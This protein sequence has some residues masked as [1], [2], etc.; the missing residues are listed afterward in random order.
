MPPVR[1]LQLRDVTSDFGAAPE[2]AGQSS[3]RCGT[4]IR[5]FE[6][7]LGF[8]RLGI[9]IRPLATTLSRATT[10]HA[11]TAPNMPAD[12]QAIYGE[13]RI[14]LAGFARDLYAKVRKIATALPIIR[15]IVNPWK[16]GA[17]HRLSPT[18]LQ[19]DYSV[20]PY[21]FLEAR[22]FTDIAILPKSHGLP[23]TDLTVKDAKW[24]VACY[25]LRQQGQQHPYVR[26]N[27]LQ[28]SSLRACLPTGPRSRCVSRGRKRASKK[29]SKPTRIS[30]RLKKGRVQ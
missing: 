1:R 9:Y 10:H 20:V 14:V 21:H 16:Y 12:Y 27:L 2:I 28:T 8:H 6:E 26:Q 5:Y 11:K 24:F 15:L 29:T 17:G 22:N 4:M 18:Q 23:H 3:K 19:Q 7:N 13:S 30:Q 25:I